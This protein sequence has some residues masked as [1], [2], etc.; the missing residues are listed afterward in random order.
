MKYSKCLNILSL[1]P[2]LHVGGYFLLLELC[3]AKFGKPMIDS[4]I[5]PKETGYDFLIYILHILML[6]SFLLLAFYAVLGV[7]GLLKKKRTLLLAACIYGVSLSIFLLNL[8]WHP[9]MQWFFD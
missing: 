1:F 8:L 2:M 4:G 3:A 9:A 5:D 6:L 7:I